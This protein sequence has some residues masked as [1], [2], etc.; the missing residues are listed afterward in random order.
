MT[1]AEIAAVKA[2]PFALKAL[3]GL[4]DRLNGKHTRALEAEFAEVMAEWAAEGRAAAAIV[5]PVLAQR[6]SGL[7]EKLDALTGDLQLQRVFRNF[8][9]EA[10]REAIAERRRLLAHASVG[11]LLDPDFTIAQKAR[12]ERTM[13]ELDPDDVKLLEKIARAGAKD[14]MEAAFQVL[15]GGGASADALLASRCV[16]HTSPV[17]LDDP[18]EKLWNPSSTAQAQLE[19]IHEAHVTIVGGWI[20]TACR[21]Y[22]VAAEAM[23]PENTSPPDQG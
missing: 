5:I 1:G 3:R 11:V 16:Q 18:V 9:Y 12:I 7:E 4:Y 22:L 6:V 13:R 23:L 20:L 14:G 10:S 17:Y 21:S 19:T 2:V 8:A 15:N